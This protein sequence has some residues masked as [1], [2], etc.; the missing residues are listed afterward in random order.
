[1]LIDASEM[2][3]LFETL[4]PFDIFLTSAVTE[5]GQS[6][7]ASQ[8]F[9]AVYQDYVAQ[10]QQ[11]ILPDEN[12]YRSVFSTIFTRSTDCIFAVPINDQHQLLRIK[13]PVVQLQPHRVSYSKADGKFRSMTFGPNTI[14]WGIQFSYPQLYQ[15][16]F[17]N[18]HQVLKNKEFPNTE[19]FQQLQKWTRSATIPTPFLVENKKINV[20]IR[21]GKNCLSWIN[22]H[23]QLI[24]QGIKIYDD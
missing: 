12:Q 22:Q 1:M 3:Q 24:A 16:E 14:S 7:V 8:K 15:D 19:L 9:L 20:P 6:Q 5:I 17:K 18:I 13:K 4:Q 11:G 10:I 2:N 23:P 21:I